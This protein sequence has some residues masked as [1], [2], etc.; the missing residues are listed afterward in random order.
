M[1][2]EEITYH[3]NGGSDR[4]IYA[5]FQ[6]TPPTTFD[7]GGREVEYEAMLRISYDASLGVEQP[8]AFHDRVTIRGETWQVLPAPQ[9]TGGHWALPLRRQHRGELTGGRVRRER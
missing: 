8:Q 2:G 4:T 5:V 6:P 1:F 7:H 9:K 3:V